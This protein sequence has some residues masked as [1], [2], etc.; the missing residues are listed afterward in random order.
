MDPT[1][2]WKSVA[3]PWFQLSW[4]P[5]TPSPLNAATNPT[6]STPLAESWLVRTIMLDVV[7]ILHCTRFHPTAPLITS[8]DIIEAALRDPRYLPLLPIYFTTPEEDP[9]IQL[10]AANRY[11]LSDAEATYPVGLQRCQPVNLL[12][13]CSL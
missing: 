10:I 7:G 4:I 3:T 6:L 12:D 9:V 11:S 8:T 5:L 2:D 13:V 1:A